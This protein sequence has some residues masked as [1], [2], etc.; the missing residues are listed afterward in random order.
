MILSSVLSYTLNRPSIRSIVR[1][2]LRPL[3]IRGNA[4]ISGKSGRLPEEIIE[5]ASSKT[6]HFQPPT[7]VACVLSSH[8][9]VEHIYCEYEPGRVCA[10]FGKS[11]SAA[12]IVASVQNLWSS[13]SAGSITVTVLERLTNWLF[14]TG[15]R[16]PLM[17]DICNRIT[18]LVTCVVG[19]MPIL[20][21]STPN[22][23]RLS[24]VVGEGREI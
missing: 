9:I 2:P 3:K 18:C 1:V 12:D 24:P 19:G 8:L 23:S 17:M 6:C 21:R 11:Y 4:S 10:G 22:R 20:D 15:G 5:M 16:K 7:V 13:T 14:I